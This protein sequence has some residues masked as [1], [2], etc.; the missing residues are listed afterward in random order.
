MTAAGDISCD[1]LIIGAGPTGLMVAY[2]LR[3]C[4]VDVRVIDKRLEPSAESRAGVM[5]SRSVELFASLGLE[6][7]IFAHGVPN[8]DF[9]IFVGGRHVGG[10]HFDHAH[11]N[12]TP[13]RFITMIPQAG[14]EAV[15]IEALT[16][17]GLAVDRGVEAK[18]F[19]QDDDGVT[20]DAVAANG[21]ALTLRARYLVGADGAHSLVRHGLGLTFEGAKYPQGFL[22]GDVQVDWD[23]PEK[24]FRVFLS[25][26]RLGLYV[27]FQ[28]H[29][30]ARVMTTDLNPPQTHDQAWSHLDLA[31]LQAGFSEA[32]GRPVRLHDPVWLTRFS[33]QHRVVDRYRVGRVFVAGDAAHIHSPAGGQGM[34]T[35]LQDAANLAWKLAAVLQERAGDALLDTY[36]AERLPV[37][38]HVLE[39]SDRMFDAAAGQTGW[40]SRLRDALAPLVIGPASQLDRV[41]TLAFRALSQIDVGYAEPD[42]GKGAS[43]P[44]AGERAPD[45]PL[46]RG[47]DLFD[48]IAG[49]GFTVLAFSRRRLN[50]HE[51]DSLSAALDALPGV[52]GR[53]AARL[54]TPFH[55]R[56]ERVERAELFE[57]YG[58]AAD[59]AQALLLVRPDGFIAWRGN[60]LDVSAARHALAA[61]L[62]KAT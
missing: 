62:H 58:L 36:E 27:P 2:L 30:A 16:K 23:L 12:D 48:L 44:H 15:L 37:A 41:Q 52:T 39:L 8:S 32:A 57:R 31:D 34:N 20:V 42:T 19:H 47:R 45:A 35:G 56:V 9:D 46:R 21:T 13:F 1:V 51:V 60:S 55:P 4:G 26:D 54:D 17:A 25:G 53:I 28:G 59:D 61:L 29:G 22:L 24:R 38:K 14:T 40:R 6:E 10:F 18:A 11:A 50:A 49:Y 33:S 43:S 7:R 5:S 3:R